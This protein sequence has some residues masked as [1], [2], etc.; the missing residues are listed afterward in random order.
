M[1]CRAP[2]DPKRAGNTIFFLGASQSSC[3]SCF[4]W[5]PC[6]S[7]APANPLPCLLSEKKYSLEWETTLS[8]WVL[9]AILMREE[10]AC[11]QATVSQ[12][13]FWSSFVSAL[14]LC[15][16]QI[17][18]QHRT[19]MMMNFRQMKRIKML[20][21]IGVIFPSCAIDPGCGTCSFS[22]LTRAMWGDRNQ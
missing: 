9:R 18:W 17:N 20:K 6:Y 4:C 12:I 22:A 14:W 2:S 16:W 13:S 5:R 3:S 11:H 19:Q 1:G 10:L 8:A 21:W 15:R 7:R